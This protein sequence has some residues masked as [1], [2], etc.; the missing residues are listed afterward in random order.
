MGADG[1]SQPDE[2]Q[3]HQAV[4]LLARFGVFRIFNGEYKL[5]AGGLPPQQYAELMAFAPTPRALST[6]GDAL[7]RVGQ[8]FAPAAQQRWSV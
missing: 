7:D 5:L 8:Y 4:R 3:S 6:V 1:L 2:R